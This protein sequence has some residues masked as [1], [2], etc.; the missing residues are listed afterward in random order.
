MNNELGSSNSFKEYSD[1]LSHLYENLK[2]I[3]KFQELPYIVA[4]IN[5][6]SLGNMQMARRLALGEW[7]KI[8]GSQSLTDIKLFLINCLFNGIDPWS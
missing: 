5:Q 6:L 2:Q 8:N 3:Q 7:D 4:I 1:Q